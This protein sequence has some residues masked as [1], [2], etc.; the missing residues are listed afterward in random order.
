M[1]NKT[2]LALTDKNG[3]TDEQPVRLITRKTRKRT[4]R[5]SLY[6]RQLTKRICRLLEKGNTITASCDSVGITDRTYHQW[7]EDHPH[8]FQATSRARGLARLRH[9]KVLTEAAKTDWR[10]SAWLL[11]HCWPQEYSEN[12]TMQID[13]RHVGVILLPQKEQKE[14]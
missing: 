14:P 12:T 4:G 7:C 10:A 6:T 8:F 2:T 11:S 9:V 5:K 13:A 1:S 3:A